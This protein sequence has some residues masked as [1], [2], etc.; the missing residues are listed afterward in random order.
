MALPDD[1]ELNDGDA[2]EMWG[3]SK[4]ESTLEPVFMGPADSGGD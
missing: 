2:A 3:G 4:C 1:D